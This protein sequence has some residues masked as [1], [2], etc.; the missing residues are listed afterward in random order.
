MSLYLTFHLLSSLLLGQA[1]MLGVGLAGHGQRKS[2]RSGCFPECLAGG[3]G[4]FLLS[5]QLETRSRE[6]RTTRRSRF[7]HFLL[8]LL[9]L[10]WARHDC[11]ATYWRAVLAAAWCAE[12]DVPSVANLNFHRGRRSHAIMSHCLGSVERRSSSCR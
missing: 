9:T 3:A 6:D 8:F 11:R 10:V 7:S 12:S 5:P 1:G 4:L 2:A